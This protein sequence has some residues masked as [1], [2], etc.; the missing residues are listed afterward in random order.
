MVCP[1]NDPRHG[2]KTIH[3]EVTGG[4]GTLGFSVLA[5]H[6]CGQHFLRTHDGRQLCQAIGKRELTGHASKP[7]RD[8]VILLVE[9]AQ[10]RLVSGEYD[11][12]PEGLPLGI[13]TK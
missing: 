13:H 6:Q 7:A 3:S 1:S 8:V 11:F 10:Q 4:G 9:A 12:C 2:R 5:A